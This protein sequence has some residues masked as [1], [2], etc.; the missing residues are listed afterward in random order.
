M[1]VKFPL[2]GY[3]LKVL[4]VLDEAPHIYEEVDYFIEASDWAV[5]QL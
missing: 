3:S 4:Q 1:E 5:W 2:N